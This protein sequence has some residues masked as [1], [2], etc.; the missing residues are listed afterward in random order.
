V[1]TGTTA[2]TTTTTTTRKTTRKFAEA[3][4]LALEEVRGG[5]TS[6]GGGSGGSPTPFQTPVVKMKTSSTTS[7]HGGSVSNLSHSVSFD[8][9][10]VL[11]ISGPGGEDGELGGVNPDDDDD[12][13]GDRDDDDVMSFVEL[14]KGKRQEMGGGEG[15]LSESGLAVSTTSTIPGS[16][17]INKATLSP[18]LPPVPTLPPP[19]I[20]SISQPPHSS[21]PQ[22]QI[23]QRNQDVQLLTPSGSSTTRRGSS[24]GREGGTTVAIPTRRHHHHHPQYPSNKTTSYQNPYYSYHHH[25]AT[26]LQLQ[27]ACTTGI[28]GASLP[29]SR[30]PS[31]SSRSRSPLPLPL[32]PFSASLPPPSSSSSSNSFGMS[33][34]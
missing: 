28:S 30:P 9:M 11:D 15:S 34:S 14:E 16:V 22:R 13:D 6:M 27:P 23:Q 21:I 8:E 19:P 20:P 12:G 24:L 3:V 4:S 2:T 32:P 1:A 33:S 17:V 5:R 31:M 26:T 7:V 18:T 29:V 10:E 25:R